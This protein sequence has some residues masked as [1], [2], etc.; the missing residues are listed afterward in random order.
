[1]VSRDFSGEEVYK[2]LVNEGNFQ[3]VR[4]TGDHLV[5]QWTHPDGSDVE[6]RTVVVPLHESISIGTLRDI[7]RDAGA[8]DFEEFCRWIDQNR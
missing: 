6:R 7:A 5:L 2:V 3:H 4:T 1:M 8:K